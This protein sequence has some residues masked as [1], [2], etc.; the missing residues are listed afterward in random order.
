MIGQS[1]AVTERRIAD[2]GDA[3]GD[4]HAGQAVAVRERQIGDSGDA[5]GDG[6]AGQAGAGTERRIPDGGDAV[7]DGYAGQAVAVIERI[8]ADGGDAGVDDDCFDF[9]SA[10]V[11]RNTGIRSII[12]HSAGAGDGQCAGVVQCPGEVIAAGTAGCCF[13]LLGDKAQNQYQCQGKN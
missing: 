6:H 10:A 9:A 13:C 5:V 2:G 1:V 4:G 12:R 8:L 7:A 11:P 3:V